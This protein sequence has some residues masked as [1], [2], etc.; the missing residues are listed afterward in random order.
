M[1]TNNTEEELSSLER[2]KILKNTAKTIYTAPVIVILSISSNAFT[3]PLPPDGD[4]A[5]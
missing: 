4:G 2:R 1:N 3:P 5:S